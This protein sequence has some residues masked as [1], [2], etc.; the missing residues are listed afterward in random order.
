MCLSPVLKHHQRLQCTPDYGRN[1]TYAGEVS[2]T[3][4]GGDLTVET[5]TSSSMALME[6]R[7][8][9]RDTCAR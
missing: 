1:D 7:A 6:A 2:E 9:E 8:Q 3:R 5:H 4:G